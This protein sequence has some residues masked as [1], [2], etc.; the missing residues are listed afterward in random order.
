MALICRRTGARPRPLC[1]LLRALRLPSIRELC[2]VDVLFD[3]LGVRF[4]VDS[5]LPSMQVRAAPRTFQPSCIPKKPQ[6]NARHVLDSDPTIDQL[7][8]RAWL[9][10]EAA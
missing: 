4:P 7:A 6:Q 10:R 9:T 2:R 8:A 1:V 5:A 3:R